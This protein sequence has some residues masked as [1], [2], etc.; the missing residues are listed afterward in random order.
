MMGNRDILAEC[1]AL[2]KWGDGPWMAVRV[3]GDVAFATNGLKV[4]APSEVK[5]CGLEDIL[6]EY[7]RNGWT[8]VSFG[9]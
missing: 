9:P 8:A 2:A 6:A 1:N 3:D 5:M 4:A 7:D